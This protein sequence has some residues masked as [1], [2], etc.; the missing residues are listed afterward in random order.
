MESN[1]NKVFTHNNIMNNNQYSY[2]SN[3]ESILKSKAESKSS[4]SSL[5]EMAFPIM[6]AYAQPAYS[7]P[8]IVPIQTRY[9]VPSIYTPD[10]YYVPPTPAIER[11]AFV[12]Y[13]RK[14]GGGSFMLSLLI[15]TGILIAAYF[16]VE[17]IVKEEKVEFISGAVNLQRQEA[18]QQLAYQSLEKKRLNINSQ[19][20][21]KRLVSNSTTASI[22]LPDVPL[23]NI[24]LPE[25]S[26]L[27]K[28]KQSSGGFGGGL[29]AVGGTPQVHTVNNMLKVFKV[30]PLNA[31]PPTLRSRCDITERLLKLKEN[32]GLPECENAVSS[33]LEYL[34][35]KQNY[36]GSWGENS[37]GAMTGL[38]LLCYFGRCETPDSPIYGDT[39]MKG[40]MY[41]IELQ[42]KNPHQLFS[43]ATTGNGA[44]YEHGIATY[45]LGEMYILARL[46][47]KSLPGMREAFEGG[48]KVIIESQRKTG[49]WC[50][51]SEL[52]TYGNS[53]DDLSVTGWQ[54]QALKAAKLT[55]LKI[56]GLHSAIS[57]V[58]DYIDSVKTVD[59]GYGT[60]NREAAYHQWGLTGAGVLGLQMLAT[61]KSAASRKGVKFAHEMFLKEPPI[62]S[63]EFRHLLYSWYYY[64]QIFFQNGGEEWQYWNDTAQPEILK[65]QSKD[66]SWS[67]SSAMAGGDKIQATAFC[68][69]M[70]EVY[71]RY[72]KVGDKGEKSIFDK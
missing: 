33:A 14:V 69:L 54:Y 41:L 67:H 71:Y 35:T 17:T 2:I 9:E 62:Y 5:P 27:M 24:E 44:V 32:G 37:K 16:I 49:G 15:H 70:L 59:G 28:V 50:Y 42:K 23:E 4:G 48:V 20:P 30:N 46:G 40:I 68:T 47:N 43:E 6:P 34:K 57:N 52:G 53:R 64:S 65:N 7:E 1:P 26:T 10:T 3:E 66:G 51:N 38:A 56:E 12:T 22:A 13:W 8:L 61:N 60:T 18:S 45:A 63:G 25:A 55:S 21:L 58:I 29:S 19:T 11:N 31:L 39:V 72:L 36:D